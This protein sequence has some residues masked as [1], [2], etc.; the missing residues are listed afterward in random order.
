MKEN[1]ITDFIN[2]VKLNINCKEKFECLKKMAEYLAK[3]NNLNSEDVFS[4]LM[5]REKFGSTA[6][7]GYFALPHAKMDS[8]SKLI[9]GIFT[10]EEPID[11]GSLDGVPSQ[12][13]LVVL[14]PSSKPS[15]LLKALAKA[16]KIFKD[17]QLKE[18]IISEKDKE[19]V[20]EFI[21][22]KEEELK[23]G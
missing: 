1:R 8:L 17:N 22:N 16:A 9:C 15:I 19:K 3:E 11:F 12:I 7:G 4:L 2:T 13:F 10:T 21:K 6:V 14:A 23:K 5:A 18:R 20:I